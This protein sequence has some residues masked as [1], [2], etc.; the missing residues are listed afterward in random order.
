MIDILKFSKPEQF[1]KDEILNE[2]D[3]LVRS[4]MS[5]EVT[6]KQ[7]DIVPVA[8]LKKVLNTWFKRG[9]TMIDQHTN[10]PIGRGLRWQE[11]VHEKSGKPGIILDYQVFDDY[12]IDDQVWDDIKTGKRSGLSIGGRA[13]EKPTMKEDDFTGRMGKYLQGLELYEV[14]PVDSPANQ[15]GT[16]IA[17]NYLAK[18]MKDMSPQE[19]RDQLLKDL[20]KGIAGEIE[21]PFAGFEN[22]AACEV[23]QKEK[24][25]SE[26][27]AKRIC[28]FIMHQTEKKFMEGSEVPK[29]KNDTDKGKIPESKPEEKPCPDYEPSPSTSQNK[30]LNK[31]WPIEFVKAISQLQKAAEP[32]PADFIKACDKPKSL[33]S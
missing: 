10:R 14:S 6:D 21:K 17:V 30:S 8:Q 16:N 33:N 28:G 20:T 5:V 15:F 32:W 31:K 13:T 22:F 11:A 3:R 9:S 18:S 19:M 26:D 12:S 27:S 25:H 1:P 29:M 4:W 7:G 2:K 24:G 23:A